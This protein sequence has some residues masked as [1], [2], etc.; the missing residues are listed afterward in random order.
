MGGRQLNPTSG[1]NLIQNSNSIS[2]FKL[3]F[4]IQIQFQNSN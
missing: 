4:K 2:K 1:A 3:N